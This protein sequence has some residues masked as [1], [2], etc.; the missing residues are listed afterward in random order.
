MVFSDLVPYVLR[1]VPYRRIVTSRRGADE[2]RLPSLWNFGAKPYTA[3]AVPGSPA[4]AGDVSLVLERIC[5]GALA[6]ATL[7]DI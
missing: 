2:I 6:G 7:E 1:F 5:P 3:S 4:V